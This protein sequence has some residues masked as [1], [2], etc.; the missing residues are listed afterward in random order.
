MK[1]SPVITLL[2]DFGTED[3]FVAAVKAVI[4]TINP[5]ASIVDITHR[6]PPQDIESGAFTLLACYNDFPAGT[7]H[8]GVVDP[9]VGSARR[10]IVVRTGAHYFVGP[11][12]GLFS[13]ICD[14]EPSR[15]VFQ[16]IAEKYF[17]P[18]LSSSFHGRD[19]FAPVAAALSTGVKPHEFGP[20]IKDEV[21]LAPLAPVK[22]RDGSLRGRIIHIDHFG[23][24]IT[25][26][27]RSD[28]PD[29]THVELRVKRRVIRTV[30]RFFADEHSL[31]PGQ[32]GAP[33][34]I[35]GSAGF[36]ELALNGGSAATLLR[37][38]RGDPVVLFYR[39]S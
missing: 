10:G 22:D 5:L 8:V 14:R 9:G 25:N 31:R 19:V 34:A 7:I 17:R 35:W 11:D 16:L 30:R 18:N 13:Y 26:F 32:H 3:Y 33:F 39:T 38:H 2:T 28:V 1:R 20:R 27:T 36:L 6:V 24:C 15:E 29:P 23:N 12:N 37:A 4:L 21:R